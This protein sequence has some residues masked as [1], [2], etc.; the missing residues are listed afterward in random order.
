[1]SLHNDALYYQ[2]QDKP[3]MSLQELSEQM[4]PEPNGYPYESPE[5]HRAAFLKGCELMREVMEWTSDNGWF[6]LTRGPS[7][8]K[9]IKQ[10]A[11][12]ITT[13][14]LITLYFARG[15]QKDKG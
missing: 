5:P 4:Y 7:K 10:W 14:E 6:R 2:R 11:E 3:P 1:M 9:W 8:G 12:P 15:E 13:P